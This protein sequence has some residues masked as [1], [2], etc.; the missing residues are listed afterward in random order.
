MCMVTIFRRHLKVETEIAQG[1]IWDMS[2]RMSYDIRGTSTM[3][4]TG[5]HIKTPSRIKRYMI[6]YIKLHVSVK[7]IIGDG[8]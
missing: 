6:E 3:Y 2:I 8:F 1:R 7:S 5:S 4:H